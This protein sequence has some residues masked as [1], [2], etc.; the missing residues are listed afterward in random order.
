MSPKPIVIHNFVDANTC[1]QLAQ[2][3]R[4]TRTWESCDEPFWDGRTL[5][6]R[7]LDRQWREE[8]LDLR[9]K[10]MARLRVE[11]ELRG[12][13]YCDVSPF[14]RWPKGT[15]Q[16]PHADAANPDGSP[17]PFSY[18]Q[19]TSLLYLNDNYEGGQV[20]FPQHGLEP[21]LKPGTLLLF[22]GDLD[23]LHGVREITKGTR[24]T[25]SGFYTQDMRMADGYRTEDQ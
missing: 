9:A 8:T 13:L 14:V 5:N 7:T 12:A 19:W 24:Y 16:K 11:F 20:Y 3:L 4:M 2:R 23:N 22:V 25:L 6:L 10:I 21:V 18:R 17:H 15:E 1:N